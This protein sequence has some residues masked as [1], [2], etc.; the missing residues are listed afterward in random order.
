MITN[1]LLDSFRF[2]MKKESWISKFRNWFLLWSNRWW[3]LLLWRKGKMW[4]CN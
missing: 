4:D 3:S 2:F 1:E